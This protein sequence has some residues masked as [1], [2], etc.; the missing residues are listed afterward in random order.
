MTQPL[1]SVVER[2]T[3]NIE[4]R[5]EARRT[6]YLQKIRQAA[7]R[8]PARGSLSCGNLAHGAAACA[9]HE[10]E[11]LFDVDA[12]VHNLAIVSAYNDMLS[13]HQPYATYPDRIKQVAAQRN[14]VAQFAGGVPAMCDGVTQGRPGMDLSLFS[15]D[16]IAMST[17][18]AL[19]HDMFD[20]AVCLGIC[21]KIVPGLLMGALAFG[22]L[23]VAFIPSGPMPSGLPNKEKAAVR[24]AYA[25]GEAGRNELI[26]AESASYHSPGTCTFYGTANS[27]QMLLE[28]MGLQLSGSSFVPPGTPLRD[29]LTDASVNQVLDLAASGGAT[30]RLGEMLT[31]KSFVN[32]CIGLLATGGSTNHTIHLIAMAGAAGYTLSWSD[33][34]ELSE[35]I[36]LLTRVYPNGTADV[37]E[38]DAAGGLGCVMTNLLDHGLLHD[39]VDTI[40]GHGLRNYLRRPELNEGGLQWHKPSVAPAD[41]SVVSTADK[42]FDAQGGLKLMAG[43][44]GRGVVKVSAVASEHRKITAPARVFRSQAEFVTAFE[45]NSITGDAVI[46]LTHQGPRA[47]GMPELHKLTPY[48]GVLQGRGQKV[49]LVTDGRMSGASGKVLAAIH[50]TPEASADGPLGRVQDGDLVTVDAQDGTLSVA[51]ELNSRQAAQPDLS[52]EHT[53]WGRE[54]FGWMRN[55]ASSAEE[56]AT[57]LEH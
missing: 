49:A 26:A 13:A 3:H 55:Q 24:E 16:V 30:A 17:A 41:L 35:V 39:E 31:A 34:S 40:Q 53:G 57:V 36:P 23:P 32:A 27:N 1:H 50:V 52:Q 37:N 7:E 11:A 47:N 51:A 38:F 42:P 8:G 4:Q 12:P 28:F 43:N 10:K 20:A 15:R 54:M 45:A 22:H 25:A 29:A 44:L 19:S 46:V 6:Q 56:G 14:A 5:S 48:L 33:L 21:D 9:A 18:I 2:V